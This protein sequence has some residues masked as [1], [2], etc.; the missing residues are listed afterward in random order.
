MVRVSKNKAKDILVKVF[1]FPDGYASIC[2]QYLIWFG[3]FLGT[4]GVQAEVSAENRGG[5][6][7]IIVSPKEAPDLLE[8]I[9]RLFYRYLSLPYV[10]YLPASDASISV[11]DHAKLQLL[12]NHVENFKLQIQMKETMIQMKDISISNLQENIKSKNEELMLLKSMKSKTDIEMLDGAV[13][14]G[15]IKWGILK[16]NPRKLLER[17]RQV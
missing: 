10:E 15:E 11:E 4:L 12:K 3:E 13:S 5:K 6:T 2:A 16:I 7:A 17:I 1:E 8:D 9:E 14:I